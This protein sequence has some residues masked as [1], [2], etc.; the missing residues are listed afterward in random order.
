MLVLPKADPFPERKLFGLDRPSEEM[1][2]DTPSLKQYYIQS[3]ELPPAHQL[4]VDQV[5]AEWDRTLLTKGWSKSTTSIG[6]WL[7]YQKGNYWLDFYKSVTAYAP[8]DVLVTVDLRRPARADDWVRA[9]SG[10]L[11]WEVSRR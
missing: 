10:R 4:P 3:F 1:L 5:E 7:T 9:R 8:K 2:R 11:N 6:G